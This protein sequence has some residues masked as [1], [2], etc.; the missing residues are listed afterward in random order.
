MRSSIP[1]V[2]V[3]GAGR[4][5][6]RGIAVRLAELGYSV[7]INFAGNAEAAKETVALCQSRAKD[8][9]QKFVTSR[10]DVGSAGDRQMLL[11]HTLAE[12]GR[13]D[14]LVNNAGM[15]PRRRADIT[16][17]TVESFDEV[18]RTNL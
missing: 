15:G 1:V 16:E 13:I 14:A 17:A 6:G 2:L 10:A 8:G 11:D 7:V 12:F 5:L 9:E 18:L 4:G 3:T